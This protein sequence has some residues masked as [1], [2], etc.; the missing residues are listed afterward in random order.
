MKT[1]FII[2]C[3]LFIINWGVDVR[4]MSFSD[5]HWDSHYAHSFMDVSGFIIALIIVFLI[6]I[7]VVLGAAALFGAV[8]FIIFASLF[9]ATLSALWPIALV[10]IACCLLSRRSERRGY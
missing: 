6:A 5:I 2:V 7:G 4:W 8:V 9:F 3:C 1:L 10:V